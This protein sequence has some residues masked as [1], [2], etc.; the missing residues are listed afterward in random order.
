LY[1]FSVAVTDSVDELAAKFSK[2][3]NIA[4]FTKMFKKRL[5]DSRKVDAK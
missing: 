3:S 1:G 4:M 5:E 2:L